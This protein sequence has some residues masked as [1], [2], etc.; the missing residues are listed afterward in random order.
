MID[1]TIP[2]FSYGT[3]QLEAVQ[4]ANYGRLID[5]ER[6]A[7][8]GYELA[9][10]LIA[11]P[12]VVAVSGKSVHMIARPSGDPTARVI[13]TLLYLTQAELEASDKYE[14]PSYTRV[15]ARL[16]SGRLA[17]VYVGGPSVVQ[18]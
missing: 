12:H 8:L 1:A 13:G 18:K 17:F 16:E 10:L 5:G 6:D 2:L 14:E 15:Q 4:L 9:P 3:L 11:D 7:L